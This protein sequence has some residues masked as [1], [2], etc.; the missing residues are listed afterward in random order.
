[1]KK[2]PID[3]STF[4]I[5]IADNYLY[6]DK[7]KHIYQLITSGRYYFL[8]RPRRFGKSLL[9]ST[10][11]QI[12][13]GNKH[14]FEN[15][16]IGKEST[17]PWIE[18]PIV[19]LNFSDLDSDSPEELKESLSWSLESIA[20]EYTVDISSARSPGQKL[21]L[22]IR[23][24]SKRN[25]VVVLVD[26]YDYPLLNNL[27]DLEIAKKN[28]KVLK[29]FFSV[30]KSL[31]AHLQA[32]FI[33]GVTKF[34]KTSIFSGLN[35]LNDLTI[36]PQAADLLGYTEEEIEKYF[37]Q[38]IAS[39]AHNQRKAP[40][41]IL[42][43]MQDWYNGYRFS[44]EN[45]KVYNPFSVLYYLQD[46]RLKNYWL[47]SGTPT[48]LI[49]MLKKQRKSLENIEQVE[50]TSDGLGV[51]EIEDIP[52]IVLLFQT[53]Y[54]TIHDYNEQTQKYRL[55]YPNAEVRES[56]K[57]YL[58]AAFAHTN[59][60]NIE[61][62]TSQLAR[63]LNENNIPLFC[64]VLQSL[65]AYIPYQLHIGE[66]RYYHSMFQ[67]IGSLLSLDVQSEVSTDKGRI[68][69]VIATP[70][71]IFLFEVKLNASA[72]TAL[73]QIDNKRY[74]E[75]YMA[76]KKTIVLIGLAFRTD[77]SRLSLDCAFQVK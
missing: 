67:L 16:W 58:L 20:Q 53:G 68:D 51:V 57:K 71:H 73:K 56:F 34:S 47:E 3:V 17:Y 13:L 23:E 64:E 10:L 29:N 62:I 15:L 48:F 50:L 69:L 43:E 61:R 55:S 19:E 41:E 8:S 22:L 70:T 30:L 52:V 21:K 12:F 60:T 65:F 74:Y 45:I 1:M 77:E 6:V 9:I 11:K 14:L 36:K 59:I 27:D 7:T 5:M 40:N 76:S 75:R 33:T 35:N 54:L 24:L 37:T 44:E 2:L 18:Y 28:R 46:Q 31:D 63:S 66:E 39:V 49:E 25:R 4:E 72:Q 32:I 42:S 26:E 38:H